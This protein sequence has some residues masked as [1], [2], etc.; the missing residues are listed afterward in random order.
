MA[1]DYQ[2]ITYGVATA[3][4]H[5]QQSHS[6]LGNQVGWKLSEKENPGAFHSEAPGKQG[7][8]QF[9]CGHQGNHLIAKDHNLNLP[10]SDALGNLDGLNERKVR[11]RDVEP[12][13]GDACHAPG[14][15]IDCQVDVGKN[16]LGTVGVGERP[17]VDGEAGFD[18]VSRLE[19]LGAVDCFTATGGSA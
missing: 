2:I 10:N 12:L 4:C 15:G 3:E 18:L 17:L 19:V 1:E 6:Y 5:A 7:L 9:A 16:I 14:V 11:F 13:G 8:L